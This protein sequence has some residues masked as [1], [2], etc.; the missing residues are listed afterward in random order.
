MY[1]IIALLLLGILVTVHEGGHFLA[2]RL[3][4]IPVSEFAIGMGPKLLGWHSRK[5]GTQ[6]SLRLI[7]VGGYCAFVGED[8]V[9]GSHMSQESAFNN[10]PVWKRLLTVF[11]GPLMNFILAFVVSVFFLWIGGIV[12][13]TDHIDHFIQVSAAGPAYSA[14]LQDG[15][16]IASV[17]GV[18]TLDGT[19]DTLINAIGSYQAG[20]APL[21]M[22][23]LRGEDTFEADLTPFWDEE[24]GRYRIGITI[25]GYY[26]VEKL[27][28]TLGEAL[29]FSW[30]YCV[31]A[32][33]AIVSSLKGLITTGEGLDQV[34]GPVGIVSMVSAEVE[35]GGL[36]A[37]INLLVFISINLGTMNLLPIPGLD[38]SRLVFLIIEAIFRK[39]VPPRKEA[40]VHLIGMGVLMLLMVVLVFKDVAQLLQ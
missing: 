1:I 15:D 11:S 20:D 39:P 24:E 6:F 9:D 30:D 5:H 37:F 28:C 14:G 8:D 26:R 31:N 3:T 10:Q 27:P 32:S 36:S 16:V 17:N 12:T 33:G 29:S 22:T 4:G 2:A 13:R 23:I 34:S 19:T 35:T 21:H 18:N 25:Q 7:P 40:M 38:G